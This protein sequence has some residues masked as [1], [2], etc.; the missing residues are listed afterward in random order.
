MVGLPKNYKCINYG[1]QLMF[2][3]KI[4]C[5]FIR[6]YC[7]LKFKQMISFGTHEVILLMQSIHLRR[8]KILLFVLLSV[9]TKNITNL[10]NFTNL[11][12]KLNLKE[13]AR[14]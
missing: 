13:N 3:S 10:L 4:Y 8:C 7:D 14:L 9:Q 1:K 5:Q 12:S 6:I 11:N 2:N